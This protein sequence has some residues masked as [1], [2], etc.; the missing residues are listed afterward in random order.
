MILDI[1]DKHLIAIKSLWTQKRLIGIIINHAY[2]YL[3]TL[4]NVMK[5]N[6]NVHVRFSCTQSYI[7]TYMLGSP[8]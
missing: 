8:L 5:K 6:V 7:Y 4:L 1:K 2:I 3:Y